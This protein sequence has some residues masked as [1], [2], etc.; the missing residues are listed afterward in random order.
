MVWECVS[1]EAK[2]KKKREPLQL[3][4][5]QNLSKVPAIWVAMSE[6]R[7]AAPLWGTDPMANVQMPVS[8]GIALKNAPKLIVDPGWKRDSPPTHKT[9]KNSKN[10]PFPKS[11][12]WLRWIISTQCIVRQLL[13][14]LLQNPR[15][16]S[17]VAPEVHFCLDLAHRNRSD[18]CD[19]RLRCPSRT[20]EIAAISETRESNAALRFK[21][22]MESR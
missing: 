19:L 8:K 6:V 21:G 10:G 20:P 2:N 14:S 7:V 5:A 12:F 1:K 11:R 13:R 15:N 9:R 17:E 4:R 18:F 22:A 3:G 16:F